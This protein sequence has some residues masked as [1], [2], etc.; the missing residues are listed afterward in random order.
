[1][2]VSFSYNTRAWTSVLEQ[3]CVIEVFQAQDDALRHCVTL[4]WSRMC[5]RGISSMR[6]CTTSMCDSYLIENIASRYFKHKKMHYANV[7]PLLDRVWSRYLKHETM[8]YAN[9]WLLL[10]RE[11]VIAVLQ[12]WDD[13]LRHCVTLTWSRMCDRGISSMRRCTTPMCNSYLIENVWSRY[14]KHETTCY[15]NVWFWRI[16]TCTCGSSDNFG[17]KSFQNIDLKERIIEIKSIL[18]TTLRHNK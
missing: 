7:W 3:E 14:F 2:W 15:A 6:R 18:K 10:D 8:H 11:C 1:M 5:D 16:K 13:A 12:A 9:V 17:T 4:T